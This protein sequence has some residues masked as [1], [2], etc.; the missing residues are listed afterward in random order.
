MTNLFVIIL[1]FLFVEIF[2]IN[3]S[4]SPYASLNK[5]HP[6]QY[7]FSLRIQSQSSGS[8]F[9]EVQYDKRTLGADTDGEAG[10]SLH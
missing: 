9:V 10:L 4:L 5:V 3:I 7:K 8:G 2:K 1:P 6:I